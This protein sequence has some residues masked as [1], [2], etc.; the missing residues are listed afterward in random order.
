MN[1]FSGMSH[2]QILSFVIV[3]GVA[4]AYIGLMAMAIV[5]FWITSKPHGGRVPKSAIWQIVAVLW[6]MMSVVTLV[7]AAP[8]EKS[9]FDDAQRF[10]AM[11][12]GFIFAAIGVVCIVLGGV[13]SR[14]HIKASRTP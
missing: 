10:G 1:L 14:A 2:N 3:G 12:D 11:I 6:F 4:T 8:S 9:F 7:W 13:L 5:T